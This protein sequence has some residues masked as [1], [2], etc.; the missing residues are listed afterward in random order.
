MLTE[1]LSCAIGKF[2]FQNA[3][4]DWVEK[5]AEY[6]RPANY[7]IVSAAQIFEK[8]T[9]KKTMELQFYFKIIFKVFSEVL[10]G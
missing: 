1:S 3:R 10:S 7:R 2:T 6:R 8:K 5:W 4:G 9:L